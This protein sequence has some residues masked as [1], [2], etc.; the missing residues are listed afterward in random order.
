MS[1]VKRV[2]VA[3]HARKSRGRLDLAVMWRL[4]FLIPHH[5]ALLELGYVKGA[6]LE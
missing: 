6:P 1:G 5:T 3:K 2:V 4:L